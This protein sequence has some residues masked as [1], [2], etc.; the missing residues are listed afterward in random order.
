MRYFFLILFF[1]SNFVSLTRGQGL[2]WD[3]FQKGNQEYHFKQKEDTHNIPFANF[4]N[5]TLSEDN[6]E[7]NEDSNDEEFESSFSPLQAV[8]TYSKSIAL[9]DFTSLFSN[10]KIREKF[11]LSIPIFLRD[12]CFLI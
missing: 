10:Q 3:A 6:S 4:D 8:F 1:I 2:S 7:D 9:S 5:C 12:S 11:H